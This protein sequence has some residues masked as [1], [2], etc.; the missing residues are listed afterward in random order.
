MSETESGS[1]EK[2]INQTNEEDDVSQ[3]VYNVNFKKSQKQTSRSPEN[4]L[5]EVYISNPNYTNISYNKQSDNDSDLIQS[6]GMGYDPDGKVILQT[7]EELIKE[8]MDFDA[9]LTAHPLDK[10]LVQ[11]IYELILETV[12]CQNDRILIA[13]SWYPAELVKS[14]FMKL[15]YV[16][17]EYV[18]ECFRKNTTKVKNIKKYL[19][20]ALFNAPS[21]IDG[22]YTAEVNHDMPQ[23]VV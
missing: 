21:T 20:A 8:N 6:E 22:Y 10:E 1:E 18:M 3:E 15:K 16:H 23:F 12:L 11:G 17:I 14:K 4:K 19:L 2:F 13:S 7:Y 5:Q 9:L